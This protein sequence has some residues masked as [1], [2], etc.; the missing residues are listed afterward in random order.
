MLKSRRNLISCIRVK[1]RCVVSLNWNQR[2]PISRPRRLERRECRVWRGDDGRH[3][4]SPPSRRYHP[5]LLLSSFGRSGAHPCQRLFDELLSKISHFIC[6][7]HRYISAAVS[8]EVDTDARFRALSSSRKRRGWGRSC[9]DCIHA[10]RP[11]S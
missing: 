2:E 8:N 10:Q 1:S 6:V 3:R 5:F 11:L 4:L 7:L 9:P